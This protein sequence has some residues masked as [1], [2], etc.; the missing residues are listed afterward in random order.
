MVKK[1]H[2]KEKDKKAKAL[3]QFLIACD[4]GKSSDVKKTASKCS[5]KELEEGL[6]RAAMNGH[7]SCVEVLASSFSVDVECCDQNGITP[8][9]FAAISD[10]VPTLNYLLKRCQDNHL[11][12][13]EKRTPL[14]WAARSSSLQ[15]ATALIDACSATYSASAQSSKGSKSSSSKSGV[16]GGGGSYVDALDKSL[17]TPLFLAASYGPRRWPLC[18]LLLARGASISPSL[19]NKDGCTVVVRAQRTGTAPKELLANLAGAMALQPLLLQQEREQA[20]NSSISSRKVDIGERLLEL[21]PLY[22]SIHWAFQ[23]SLKSNFRGVQA[24]VAADGVDEDA[25]D[26]QTVIDQEE[27]ELINALGSNVINDTSNEVKEEGSVDEA[28]AG[29]GEE[30]TGDLNEEEYVACTAVAS[31]I[32]S[33]LLL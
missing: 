12:R 30:E 13:Q 17:E 23:S 9:I 28:E 7:K 27:V 22:R 3:E 33:F 29:G 1:E 16:V 10:S 14:H 18:K 26:R 24:A 6:L 20:D 11:D 31:L 21:L 8:L 32:L 25:R 19:V 5:K 2:S 4:E 15:T